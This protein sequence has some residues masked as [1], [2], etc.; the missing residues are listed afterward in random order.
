[1]CANIGAEAARRLYDAAW[2][3]L[4]AGT[5]IACRRDTKLRERS[6]F[7]S[8]PQPGP[9]CWMHA[10]SVGEVGVALRCIAALRAARPEL[11]FTLTTGTPEGRALADS[12]L[13][14]KD[15]VA[16]FPFDSR[17]AMRRAYERLR[18]KFVVLVEVELW[19]NHLR[20]AQARDIP[21]FVVN[22]RM[23]RRDERAYR[24]AGEF[25]RRVFAIPRLVC[26][27]TEE[28][29]DRF[30]S[31]GA[32]RVVVCG[33]MKFD[34]LP[35][36]QTHA[37][38]PLPHL[39]GGPVLL[40]AS[41]HDGEEKFLLETALQIRRTIP[42]LLPVIVPRHPRRAPAIKELAGRL[43]FRA[44]LCSQSDAVPAADCVVVDTVG[45]LPAWYAHA[46]VAF[47]GKSLT[48]RGGQNFLE[49]VEAGCPVVIGPHIEHFAGAS[50]AFVAAGAVAQEAD[51]G[52]V[53][54]R[55]AGILGS[56]EQGR[57]MAQKASQILRDNRG[58]SGRT[59]A[60]IL[61]TL[62]C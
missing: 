54:H 14:P 51:A 36:S 3:I 18:P 61:D 13:E 8:A 21:V 56:P 28:D 48:A 55:L 9:R 45:Q 11:L 20:E 62:G 26:A 19:P 60:L 50:R 42:A 22:G 33:N 30:L 6:G 17:S 39:A 47:V 53:A 16:W 34:P 2:S 40:G 32:S 27:Q 57:M 12:R 24:R 41:T 43:G 7:Y 31:L 38:V 5:R 1:M 23:S 35:G 10:C 4:T 37:P 25:M 44:V 49:A 46:A 29:A 15:H 52:S 59:A 58:A